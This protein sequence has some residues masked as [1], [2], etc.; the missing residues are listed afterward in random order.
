MTSKL[1][2]FA[3]SQRYSDEIN[4]LYTNCETQT[5]PAA[6]QRESD[7]LKQLQTAMD[8]S[9]DEGAVFEPVSSMQA[10]RL[11]ALVKRRFGA[12]V[13]QPNTDTDPQKTWC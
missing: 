13:S 1:R 12:Q 2:R 5:A 8:T 4:E 10:V 3:L 9:E 11:Q 6:A 7:F